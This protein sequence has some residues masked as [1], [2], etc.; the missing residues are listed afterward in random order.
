MLG[1]PKKKKR[2]YDRK[3]N[4]A[5]AEVTEERKYDTGGVMGVRRA[6]GTRFLK[7]RIAIGKKR[8]CFLHLRCA[9]LL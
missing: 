6:V 8:P 1:L 2:D 9:C 3:E 4:R 7:E 5:N